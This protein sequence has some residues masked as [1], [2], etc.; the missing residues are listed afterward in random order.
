[1]AQ[2]WQHNEGF[3]VMDLPDKQRIEDLTGCIPLLLT[4]FISK[5]GKDLNQ[6]EPAIWEDSLLASVRD[7]VLAFATGQRRQETSRR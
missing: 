4:P 6:L 5:A 2:W 7:D 3:L 1:M